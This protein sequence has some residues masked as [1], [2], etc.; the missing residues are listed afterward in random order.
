M[1]LGVA[2]CSSTP[3]DAALRSGHADQAAKLYRTGAEQ[4]DG[5][6]ALKLG[7]LLIDRPLSEYGPPGPWFAKGCALGNVVAC[8]NAG[9]GHEYG[10]HGSAI[11]YPEAARFYRIAAQKGYM[12]SQYNLGSLYSNK[13]L[14]DDVEGLR[15]LLIS[16]RQ[17]QACT[18][19]PVCKLTLEDKPN[20]LGRL[21]SRMSSA[22]IHAAEHQAASWV[23][24]Q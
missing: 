1:A 12:Q 23:S 24:P 2:A 19:V 15:W 6:A 14:N 21:R 18:P 22:E 16:R 3:G 4:G 7:V 5:S 10:Q 9:V 11:N 13:H 8:H 20:H 17:A